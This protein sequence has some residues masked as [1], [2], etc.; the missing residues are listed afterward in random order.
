MRRAPAAEAPPPRLYAMV[1]TRAPVA[2]VFRLGPHG[3]WMVG[4]WDL[5]ATAFS[6]GAWLRGTLYP[7][8][9]DLSPDG[10]FLYSFV[11]KP[12]VRGFLGGDGG[13]MAYSTV[14]KA[15]WLFALAAWK[16][17]GT[18]T[19]G[20][21]F[22]EAGRAE[23]RPWDIGDPQ[24]GDAAP[25]RA[26]YGMARTE[27]V[28]YA[29]ERR[30]GWVEHE[31]CP[32]RGPNDAWDE[33]RQVILAKSRPG[34]AGRLVLADRG[35]NP[36]ELGCI[37]GRRPSYTLEMGR[38]RVELPDVVWAEW[39]RVG[40]LLVATEG[41]QLQVRNPDKAEVPVAWEHD[42]APLTP[43][44]GPAPGWARRW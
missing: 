22:V 15:P 10:K 4:R 28:Q 42:L 37:E 7:R 43:A 23:E 29:V 13:S 14:S 25:L 24:E 30:R 34:G 11:L 33:R 20:F 3:V 5:E 44:R 36:A 40:R 26:R 21:H 19:R 17:H 41:G 1:A 31:R 12:R 35:W 2:V 32:P 27:A 18:W 9:C 16:E 6:P 39:D 38:R 8:R